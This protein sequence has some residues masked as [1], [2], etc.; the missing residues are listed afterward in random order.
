MGKLNTGLCALIIAFTAGCTTA[1]IDHPVNRDLA[2]AVLS[3]DEIGAKQALVNG[4]DKKPS[5]STVKP[6]CTWPPWE[7]SWI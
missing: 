7:A 2:I 4:A 3:G 6:I 1:R 5:G